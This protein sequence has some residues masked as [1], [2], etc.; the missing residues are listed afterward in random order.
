MDVNCECGYKYTHMQ[1]HI[2]HTILRK[3]VSIKI[4]FIEIYMK[5]QIYIRKKYVEKLSN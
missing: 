4:I 5:S 3:Q 1:M 2:F